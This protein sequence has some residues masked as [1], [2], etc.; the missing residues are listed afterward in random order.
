MCIKKPVFFYK[1]VKLEYALEFN[2][3]MHAKQ[4]NKNKYFLF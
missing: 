2:G 4:K 1:A 3:K